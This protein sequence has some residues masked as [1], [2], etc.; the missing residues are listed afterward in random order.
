M[1]FED[2]ILSKLSITYGTDI[3][4]WSIMGRDHVPFEVMTFRKFLCTNGTLVRLLSRMS[5]HVPL[6][7]VVEGEGL[8]A[9]VATKGLFTS[10]D[11]QVALDVL[12]VF[13]RFV[14]QGARIPGNKNRNKNI[15]KTVWN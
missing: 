12:A 6:E 3:R 15:I 10:V 7:I 14:A 8:I 13:E 2:R 9:H 4:G 1:L 11:P 5:P